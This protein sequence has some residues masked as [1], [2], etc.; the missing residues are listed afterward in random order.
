MAGGVILLGLVAAVE[1]RSIDPGVAA[2][3]TTQILVTAFAYSLAL[4]LL[5][6]LYGARLRT[7]VAAPAVF[8]TSSL[9]AIRLLWSPDRRPRRIA[10]YGGVIGLVVAQCAWVLG[11]WSI[12]ALSGATILLLIFYILTGVAQ[13][14]WEPQSGPR[15]LLEYTFTTLLAVLVVL[16]LGPG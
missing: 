13:I 5:A 1:Y 16:I 4:G 3:G 7:L 14:V 15:A 8:L 10:L 2:R 12:P 9:L 6:L 11:Y